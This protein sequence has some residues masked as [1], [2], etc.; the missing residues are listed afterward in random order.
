MARAIFTCVFLLIGCILL[1]QDNA[2]QALPLKLNDTWQV[3]LNVESPQS[4]DAVPASLKVAGRDSNAT[5]KKVKMPGDTIDLAPLAG[6]FDAGATA[7]LYNEFQAPE[8]GVMQAGAAAD[9]WMEIYVN[10]KS[11]L[12]TMDKG[13]GTGTYKP[14]D[15]LFSFPVKAGRNVMAVKVKSGSAGWRFVC[16]VPE[17][18]KPNVKFTAND[19]WKAVD[20]DYSCAVKEGSAL[21]QRE[22]S[23]L[24]RPGGILSCI[25]LD[26]SKALPR[27]GIGPSGKLVVEGRPDIQVRL[28]GTG[29]NTPWVFGNAAKN[30]DWKGTW[31]KEAVKTR[32]FGYNLMRL[33]TDSIYSED[34]NIT[35][36][37]LDKFDYFTN[38]FAEQGVYTFL[39]IGSY[40]MYLK[41]AWGP[42]KDGERRDYCLRMYLGDENIRKAWKYGVDTIMNHVNT[43]AGVA[44]KDD[45]NIACIELFNEQEWGI[46]RP[47]KPE[48][49]AEFSAKFRSWLQTKYKTFDALAKAWG[50]QAPTSFDAITVPTEFPFGGK[51]VK[52]NDF[53]LFCGELS[54][55][56][57]RWM[58]ETLR[59]TGYKGLIAQYN[60]SHWLAG[61]EARWTESPVT[62]ANTYH[63][64]PSSFDSVGSKCGQDSSIGSGAW[65]WRGIASMRFADRPFIETEFNHSFWNPYQHECGILFG[66]YSALQ[67]MDGMMIH[68][69]VVFSY[70][71]RP[72][73]TIGTFS[74][75]SSPV[76]RAGEFLFANLY[77]RGDVK[78]SPHRVELQIPRDFLETNSN[79]GRSVSSEQ[80][81]MA[82]M[83]GFSIA[84]PWAP[85]PEGVGNA[86]APDLTMPPDGGSEFKSAGGG[87]AINSLDAKSSKFSLDT[88]VASMKEKGILPKD[89]I[90]EPSK[91]IFQSDTGEIAMRTKENLMKVATPRSEA[92]TLEGGKGEPVGLLTV[93]S[94]SV[95]AMVAATAVDKEPLASSKRVVVLYSTYAVN[96]GMELSSD[97]T[98]L[99]NLGKMPV[100]LRTGKLEVALKNSNGSAMSLYALGFDG[101][102]REKLPL[103]FE[104]G[105]LKISIDTGALKNGPTTFFELVA[106]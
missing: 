65:Y 103:K 72:P 66:A 22:I 36:D 46:F 102:R 78:P 77:L 84:F 27:L 83:T 94:T 76:A 98:T 89:N 31:T 10:G 52:D 26:S 45:P 67:D 15:H 43:Y 42:L 57:A 60:I 81:K 62:I 2:T 12:S 59:A 25:G 47:N 96:S 11:V 61:Q 63:N 37:Q 48:T 70:T 1:G 8:A 14:N 13:N 6:G 68:G 24:P 82:F 44:W 17:A 32:L 92:V 87:W 5:P 28:R 38:T 39:T 56:N 101:E 69:G 50:A 18:P 71:E 104:D 29:S 49:I 85:R 51:H 100:L 93:A 41:N 21:D 23:E 33:S 73:K 58:R 90:S 3:F 34:L 105:I 20:L 55:E 35:P 74:V 91:G 97:R 9:W 54:H 75:S 106:E 40:G 79:G 30:P 4:Y 7:I 16:G 99:V 88:A 86:P 95:P 19:E 53:I 80:G 64:H